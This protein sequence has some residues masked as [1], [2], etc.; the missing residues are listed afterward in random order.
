MRPGSF[1]PGCPLPEGLLWRRGALYARV[2]IAGGDRLRRVHAASLGEAKA[3]R[4]AFLRELREERAARVA[5]A[6]AVARGDTPWAQAVTDYL[7]AAETNLK[8]AT[9]ERYASSLRM[10]EPWLLELTIGAI[11][12]GVLMGLIREQRRGGA[13]NAT[14]NRLLTAVS[15]VLE[16]AVVEGRID[17]NP[18]AAIPRRRVTRERRDPIIPPTTQQ[19]MAV[20]PRLS[21]TLLSIARFAAETGCRQAEAEQLEW[22]QIRD[23][24]TCVFDRTKSSR[25]RV[26]DLHP[27]TLDWMHELKRPPVGSFVFWHG[28]GEPLRETK[29]QFYRE[30]LRM[31]VEA[32]QLREPFRRFRF[33]DL[34]HRFATETL[35]GGGDLYGLSRHMGHSTVKVTEE[36]LALVSPAART[37][38]LGGPGTKI[39]SRPLPFGPGHC[40]QSVTLAQKP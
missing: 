39:T 40:R 12:Q 8:P 4:D 3:A 16:H 17:T 14:I 32:E 2:Q 37:R 5:K 13:K 38:A 22:W 18:V 24:G 35:E 23:D 29:T 36:Y 26:I 19:V 9:V 34:R 1:V 20:L 11:D 21:S 30:V 33:H 25:P 7:E 10:A 31:A 15:Q 28:K 6:V 27:G